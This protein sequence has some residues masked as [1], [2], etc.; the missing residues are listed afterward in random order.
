MLREQRVLSQWESKL[1]TRV[2]RTFKAVVTVLP[3]CSERQFGF[4]VTFIEINV[5]DRYN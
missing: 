1:R 3:G 2:F 5:P 4:E